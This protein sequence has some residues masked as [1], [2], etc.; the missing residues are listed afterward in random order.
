[1]MLPARAIDAIR[2]VCFVTFSM[3]CR[4]PFSRWSARHGEGSRPYG[5]LRRTRG[6]PVLAMRRPVPFAEPVAIGGCHLVALGLRRVALAGRGFATTLGRR[7]GKLG[8]VFG[9]V[10][11]L[12]IR[13]PVDHVLERERPLRAVAS[14]IGEFAR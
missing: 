8:A 12:E 2:T 5:I 7:P 13:D 10:G 1:M 11:H 14:G 4:D 9:V 6:H 3:A